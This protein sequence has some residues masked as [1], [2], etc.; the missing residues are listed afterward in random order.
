MVSRSGIPILRVNTVFKTH[1]NILKLS[2]LKFRRNI[3]TDPV[4]EKKKKKKKNEGNLHE[5]G[6][7]YMQV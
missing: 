5:S 3:V 7:I 1:R 2:Y 4:S 6:G